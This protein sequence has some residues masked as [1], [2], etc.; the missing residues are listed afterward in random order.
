ML[1]KKNITKKSLYDNCLIF[2]IN[3]H[4]TGAVNEVV[5]SLFYKK[6]IV[7][8]DF[9]S[10]KFPKRLFF[11]MFIYENC[12]EM[13]VNFLVLY[14]KCLVIACTV[15]LENFSLILQQFSVNIDFV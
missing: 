4:W 15:L 11:F 2:K 9:W 7:S 8:T 5:L 12:P 3:V 10:H 1:K 13:E 14:K 6:K